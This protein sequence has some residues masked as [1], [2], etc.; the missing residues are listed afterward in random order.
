MLVEQA[1][2]CGHREVARVLVRGGDMLTAQPELLHDHV[3]GDAGSST[4]LGSRQPS[5]REIVGRRSE[6]DA[7]VHAAPSS[8]ADRARDDGGELLGDVG[9]QRVT[10]GP[11][12]PAH[13]DELADPHQRPREQLRVAGLDLAG[14]HRLAQARDVAVRQPLVVE[15]EDLRRD[16]LGL[17]DD[18]VEGGM[19]GRETEERCEA[20]LLLLDTGRALLGSLVMAW[21]TRWLRSITSSSKI[22]FFPVK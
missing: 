4:D 2:G 15:L 7:F 21:R 16:E 6:P 19:L 5:F 12:D 9:R 8:R 10:P 13:P 17:A 11:E 1:R 20:E 22:S 14:S 18:P 3:L